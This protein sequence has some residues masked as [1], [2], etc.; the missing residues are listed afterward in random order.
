MAKTASSPIVQL[1]RRVSRDPRLMN[2]P[3]QGLLRRFLGEGDEAAFEALLQRHGPMVLDVCRG[4]LGNEA[5]AEDAFQATFL[6]LARKAGSI[7]QAASLASWLHGVARRTALRARADSARRQRHEA[8]A[9]ER[10]AATDPDEL[11]WREVRQAVHEELDRLPERHRAALVLCYL[12]GRTQDEAAAQLGLAKGTLKGHLERGRALLRARL[13][14]RGLGPGAVVVLGAW[15]AASATACLSPA[16]LVAA[17]KGATAVASGGAAS[18]VSPNVAA[19][20]EGMVK[21]M[22]VKKLKIAA[23]LLL[24]IAGSGM[25]LAL[26]VRGL[27][28]AEARGQVEQ[29]A[30]QEEPK[31]SADA[32]AKPGADMS[33]PIRSLPGHS[34]RLTSVAYSP[35]GRWIATAAWDG[36]ARLWDAQTGKEVRRLDMSPSKWQNPA[37]LTQ[38]LFSPDNEF[39]VVAQQAAPNEAGVIVWN[40]RTGEKV[41]EFPGG[42][43]SVAVSPDGRFI[44]CGGWGRGDDVNAGVVRLYELATGKPVRELHG[45]Q[46]RIDLLAFS[47]DG[48]TVIA[49]VG[50]PRPPL[51]GGRARLGFDPSGV[52]AWDVATGKERRS[53]LKAPGYGK[54]FA[55][56]PDGRTQAAGTSLYETATGGQRARLT[57]HTNDVCAVAFSPDGRTLASGSMDGTVRLWALPSG[58]EVAR[59]GEEVPR[60][61]GRG[62][63]LSVAFSPDGKTLVSGGLDKTAHLWD[64]SRI[65]GRRRAVA[66]RSSPELEADWKDLAGDAATGY[67]A[68]GRLVLSPERAV[69]FLGKQLQSTKPVDVRRIERLIASLD[70]ER[71]EVREQATRELEAQADCAAPALRRALAGKPSAEARQRLEAL[72]DRLD[73]ASP[74]AETVR[75][76]RA[77]EALEGIGNPEARRLLDKLAAGPPET[78]LTEEAK[79]AAGRLAKRASAAP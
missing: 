45:H 47:P 13:V 57:G 11:T 71:F 73:G 58:K 65:T 14:R 4:V 55:T 79:A 12:E 75:Q 74:S 29:P 20:T 44:A 16:L 33:M 64:V 9:P 6:L 24:A 51:E 56:S 37:H 66:E 42:Y 5:D 50:I 76:I 52:R 8:R 3:D 67:A 68:L 10:S 69:A 62:W 18:A 21:A 77:V 39:V 70:D 32:G 23:I 60:F 15:P 40:R 31:R 59:L 41:H 48:Q 30:P 35:D 78:R 72:L 7:R 38:I 1:I 26:A 49:Q 53:T 22:F 2:S 19:L 54:Q 34:D 36:T 46:S 17:V 28:R 25:G 27:P 43:G 61:A 63:V